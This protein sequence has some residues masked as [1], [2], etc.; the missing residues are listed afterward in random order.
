VQYRTPLSRSRQRFRHP[1][2]SVKY[3]NPTV[4]GPE[5]VARHIGGFYLFLVSVALGIGGY[6][7]NLVPIELGFGLSFILG[8]VFALGLAR[9]CFWPA[10]LCAVLTG[11]ATHQIWGHPI[12]AVVFV[13]DVAFVAWLARRS[14]MSFLFPDA[15]FWLC[16]GIPLV[17]IGYRHGLRMQSDA[18]M[19]VAVKQALNNI[20]LS[21]AAQIFFLISKS[22]LIA[23]SRYRYVG[24]AR[25]TVT[26]RDFLSA[27][28]VSLV[29][30][31]VLVGLVFSSHWRFTFEA[32]SARDRLE[33]AV[34][35]MKANAVNFNRSMSRSAELFLAQSDAEGDLV[36]DGSA[37][38]YVGDSRV[39]FQQNLIDVG[40]GRVVPTPSWE[41]LPVAALSRLVDLHNFGK[42]NRPLSGDGTLSHISSPTTEIAKSTIQLWVPMSTLAHWIDD[43]LVDTELSFACIEP[44]EKDPDLNKMFESIPDGT[45]VLV[46]DRKPGRSLMQNWRD[47]YYY[48]ALQL[49]DSAGMGGRALMRIS[50]KTFYDRLA[51][52]TL[53]ESSIACFL[54]FAGLFLQ[55]AATTRINRSLAALPKAV[56][57]LATGRE[58]VT[59]VDQGQ[60]FSEISLVLDEATAFAKNL[61]LANAELQDT[62]DLLDNIMTSS[63]TIFFVFGIQGGNLSERAAYTS[64]SIEK[65]LR[66]PRGQAKL[67]DWFDS[68]VHPEDRDH[69][70]ES[71][72]ERNRALVEKGSW[73]TQ[74]RAQTGE[75]VWSTFEVRMYISPFPKNLLIDQNDIEVFCI[76]TDVSTRKRAEDERKEA[77]RQLEHSRRLADIGSLATGIAHELNQP[78]NIIKLASTNLSDRIAADDVD[79]DTAMSKLEIIIGQ[80]NRAASITNH[81]RLFGRADAMPVTEVSLQDLLADLLPLFQSQH[82]L[83]QITVKVDMPVYPVTVLADGVKLE[84]VISNV[85]MNS[86]NQIEEKRELEGWDGRSEEINVRVFSD[87]WV[88]IQISD[89]AG[90]IDTELLPR[91]FQPFVTSRSPGKGTGLGLSVAY[92]I[93]KEMNGELTARNHGDGAT[94]TIRL[95]R[96]RSVS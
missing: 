74:I 3:V 72:S 46:L 58:D 48:Q 25:P 52:E 30:L 64:R 61:A 36:R 19:A 75:D 26:I 73:N 27:I 82:S 47:G 34:K 9:L 80:V 18:A 24:I 96:T 38:I 50:L 32:Q 68:L 4:D 6:L 84:Q 85:L 12:A 79:K 41:V 63:S 43:H 90:G 55:S 13:L 51:Q 83:K 42:I 71:R 65:I 54:V 7:L 56:E 40:D 67:A 20:F 87:E 11:A 15:V 78:L 23:R 35:M 66:F 93:V 22:L 14:R 70:L 8:G 53:H 37:L 91:I 1:V 69:L 29:V 77:Q 10:I 62:R 76:M 81:M 57:A 33:Q 5:T 31:P 88:T 2:R 94:F 21:L 92:G 16:V 45:T 59:P 39:L 17:W 28:M 49:T 44:C 60:Y 89:R 95:P 86:C